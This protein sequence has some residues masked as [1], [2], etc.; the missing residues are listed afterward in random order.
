M[1]FDDE[2]DYAREE[3]ESEI[4]AQALKENALEYALEHHFTEIRDQVEDVQ[5]NE[6]LDRSR[7]FLQ[8]I[9]I[10]SQHDREQLRDAIRKRAYDQEPKQANT[11]TELQLFNLASDVSKLLES[12]DRP[13]PGADG[14]LKYGYR[15]GPP[16]APLAQYAQC[17]TVGED[18]AWVSD[19]VTLTRALRDVLFAIAD[20]ERRLSLEWELSDHIRIIDAALEKGTRARLVYCGLEAKRQKFGREPNP[21]TTPLSALLASWISDYLTTYSERIDLGACVECG[22]IFPRQRRDN[23]YCSKTC[24]NRV[25]YKR[26][27][28][29]EGGLLKK[30]EVTPKTIVERLGGGAWA[31]HSRLGLGSVESVGGEYGVSVTVRFPQIARTFHGKELFQSAPDNA[32]VEFYAETDAGALAELL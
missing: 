30:I 2:S 6:W 7:N 4:A 22:K 27:K 20:P 28:I 14:S 32:K 18:L 9:N 23:A 24:Q 1:S 10:V 16:T 8:L 19:L 29:F 25:A 26:R 5:A 13:R 21:A 3:Y 11:T 31:Y 17:C 15:P 12:L